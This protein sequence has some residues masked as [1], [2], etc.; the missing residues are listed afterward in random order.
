MTTTKVSDPGATLNE[1]DLDTM[2]Q[3][4]S[5][6]NLATLFQRGKDAGLITAGKE[7]GNAT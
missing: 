2:V 4:A 1:D 5:T 6:P 3:R 7:Y